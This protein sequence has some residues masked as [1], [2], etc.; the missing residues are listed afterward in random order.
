MTEPTTFC[1]SC[2]RWQVHDQAYCPLFPDVTVIGVKKWQECACT[3]HTCY[4]AR[5]LYQT[6]TGEEMTDELVAERRADTGNIYTDFSVVER[7]PRLVTGAVRD[8][9][10]FTEEPNEKF[11]TWV[12]RNFLDE[13][14]QEDDVGWLET[15]F[16][17]WYEAVEEKLDEM[18]FDKGI[19]MAAFFAGYYRTDPR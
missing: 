3:V 14:Q 19:A 10:I 6:R 12:I 17:A 7:T 18:P 16:E 9:K 5:D 15:E 8:P 1:D 2:L 4:D 13:N 11:V